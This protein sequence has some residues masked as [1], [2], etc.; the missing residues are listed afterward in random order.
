M[1]HLQFIKWIKQNPAIEKLYV[2]FASEAERNPYWLFSPILSSYRRTFI[3]GARELQYD[4]AMAQ[5]AAITTESID[6]ALKGG[7]ADTGETIKALFDTE[8]LIEW[9]D[10]Q[11]RSRNFP[12]FD[13]C[14]VEKVEVVARQAAPAAIAQDWAKFTLT[15]RVTYTT[16]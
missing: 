3:T 1:K 6:A 5:F 2:I 14:T 16:Y 13:G 11:N 8:A 10:E 4:A 15:I 7:Y 9:V 12:A